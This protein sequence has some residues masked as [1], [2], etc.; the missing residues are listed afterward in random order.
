MTDNLTQVDVGISQIVNYNDSISNDIS[1]IK[2]E[3]PVSFTDQIRPACLYS[4]IGNPS[5]VLVTGWGLTK[6]LSKLII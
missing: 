1:I 6:Q 4:N 2:L 5:P 3:R